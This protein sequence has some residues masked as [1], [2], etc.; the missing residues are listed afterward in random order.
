M[1]E[2]TSKP[3]SKYQSAML[4]HM[5]IVPWQLKSNDQDPV[6]LES[7]RPN[8]ND[9]SSVEPQMLSQEQKQAGLQRLRQKIET[10]RK[11]VNHDVLLCLPEC[12]TSQLLSDILV[13]ADLSMTDCM[14]EE[15][16]DPKDYADFK[17][18][19]QVGEKISINGLVLTA[20]APDQITSS[21]DKKQLWQILHQLF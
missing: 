4:T 8:E 9:V 16:A 19:W 18:V 1:T 7:K 5:G 11:S 21:Q 13:F 17:L 20:P 6:N 15:S 14:F 12:K 10:T 3:L 2:L